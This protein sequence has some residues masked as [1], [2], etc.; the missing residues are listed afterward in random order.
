MLI[1]N[2]PYSNSD[3]DFSL[4]FLIITYDSFLQNSLY[5]K[6]SAGPSSNF[7]SSFLLQTRQPS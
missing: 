3:Q 4:F 1:F 2:S 7:W 5:L 6:F